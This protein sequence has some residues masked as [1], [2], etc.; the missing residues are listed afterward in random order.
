MK[1]QSGRELISSRAL[2]QNLHS[3]QFSK[4]LSRQNS[5]APEHSTGGKKSKGI[6]ILAQV[7]VGIWIGESARETPGAPKNTGERGEW[8]RS[9]WTRQPPVRG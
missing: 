3:F 4:Q 5:L 9:D 6:E 8:T 1:A 7:E 2:R